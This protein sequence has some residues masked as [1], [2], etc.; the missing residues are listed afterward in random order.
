MNTDSLNQNTTLKAALDRWAHTRYQCREVALEDEI[1]TTQAAMIEKL[2][3]ACKLAATG[4]PETGLEHYV[5]NTLSYALLETNPET[6]EL[7]P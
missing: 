7:L 5:I 3:E 1:I 6:V 4:T 2:R